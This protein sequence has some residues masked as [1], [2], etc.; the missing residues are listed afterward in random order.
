M[1]RLLL[2]FG[3][4][5]LL[6]AA[7]TVGFHL[8]EGWPL[9]D[10]FYMTL[11][12]LTTVGYQEVHP[13]S[14]RGRVFDSALILGGVSV[15]FVSIAI[16]ADL[17]IKLELADYFGH[18]RSRKML[19]KLSDHYIVCGA[20]RVG[21][22]V[23][24]ELRR[25][26]VP[27]VLIDNDKERAQWGIDLGIPTL[28]ADATLDETLRQAKI[29]KAKGL[30]AAIASDAQNV[31]VTLSARVLNPNILISARA[32]DEQAE[33]KL[34]R[35]G[36]TT[37]FTPYTFIG[38][39]LAQSMLRPHV[40][41]FLDVASAFGRGSELE[42]EIEQVRVA[43]SSRVVSKTLGETRLRQTLGV[44]VLAVLKPNGQMQFN[45]AS[46]TAIEAGDVLIAMGERSKLKELEVTLEA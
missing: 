26:N 42:I 21:R 23:V 4:M 29:E 11:T 22:G 10:S 20:G 34:R 35:A 27:V 18:R 44:I 16:L 40:M 43:E 14:L 31:Y 38:H 41:S 8:I 39:R 7:G 36:V 33:E 37:V 9:F 17:V 28:I 30:V 15:L 13:L 1:R 2:A 6:L 5:T 45:P 24:G 25:G 32:T 19:D 12:T 3:L 46:S